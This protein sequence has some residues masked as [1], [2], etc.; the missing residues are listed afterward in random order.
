M[1]EATKAPWHLWAVGIVGLLWNGFGAFDFLSTQFRGEAYLRDLGMNDAAIA[2]YAAMP[3]W[4]L[5]I[6]AVGTLGAL[7]ATILL[8]LHSKWAFA[9]F[10]VSFAGFLLS[11]VYSYL[12]STP[13]DMGGESMWIMQVVIAAACIFFI[14]Y[15]WAMR[16]RGVLR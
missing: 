3:W 9:V 16:R 4:A 11:L 5:A 6:W 12:L 8:L 13:P 2:Y 7:I 10:A 15:A 1:S 14:W